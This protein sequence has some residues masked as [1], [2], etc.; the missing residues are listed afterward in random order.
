MLQNLKPLPNMP[1][2]YYMTFEQIVEKNG[3]QVDK[4]SV[5]TPDHY[6]LGNF[7]IRTPGLKAGAPVIFMQ[8]G[9]FDCSDTWIINQGL[10]APA[11][12]MASAGYDVFLGNNRGNY[13]SD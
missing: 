8:H 9:L 5:T 12:Q 7:R 1:A 4:Y 2:E 6:V 11:F 10:L 3:F 13:Y